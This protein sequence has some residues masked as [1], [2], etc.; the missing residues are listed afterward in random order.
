MKRNLFLSF[1]LLASIPTFAQVFSNKEVG[2]KNEVLVD[3]LKKSEYP[4]ALPIWGEKVT[5][6]GYSLPYS[7]GL[8]VQYFWQESAIIIDNLMV[9]FNNGEMYNVDGIVRFDE[10]TARAQAITVRPDVWVLPFLDVYG[11]FGTSNAATDI[12]FGVWAPDSTGV[13][14]EVLKA[15]TVV[16]FTTTTYGFGMTPTIGVAGG[17][18]ALDFNM[19][20]TDVPQLTKP[21][22]S[23]VFGPRFG[24][25]FKLKKP[26]QTIAVWVGGFRVGLRSETAGSISLSEVFPEGGGEVG[27][28]IDQGIQTVGDAQEQVDA[29]W[30]D[31]TEQEQN[32]P[33]NEAKYETAN[34]ALTKAGEIL[35]AADA[36]VN[37]ISTSTVQYSM[38]KT[39][40]D[41]WNFVVGSQFQYNKHWMIRLEAG[42]LGSRTQVMTGL[43]YRFG[44]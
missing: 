40:K 5:K 39:I 26:D 42:F 44:L 6:A 30:G 18:L 43:Q 29:W 22:R 35:S 2:K 12:S 4:Y 25:N 1:C 27:M 37:T 32:N 33:V 8:S 9:G 3:S 23:T 20:W 19:A 38:D 11:I 34:N 17:F 14:K 13:E 15:G 16:E 10:S 31:L 28:K 41:A 24:K 7:A 21:A 36:A